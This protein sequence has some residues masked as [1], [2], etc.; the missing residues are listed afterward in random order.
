VASLQ[1]VPLLQGLALAA[2]A[3]GTPIFAKRWLGERWA[4]PL[5]GGLHLWDWQPLFGRSKT[6]RG[7]V[8]AVTTTALASVVMG[9]GPST[10]AM[11][12]V[13]AM[14]GDLMSSFTKR[15]LRLKPSSMAP[16]L[17]QVPEVLLPLLAV[18]GRLGLTSMDIAVGV[19]A[20]WL[21]EIVISRILFALKI[22][23]RPY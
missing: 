16:G 3:N 23:D 11:A 17:D 6:I 1:F 7:L 22:R 20:F 9:L 12:G 19:A 5:D 14:A 2:V 21:G 10:G 4:W 18:A 15:R 13:A 8:L